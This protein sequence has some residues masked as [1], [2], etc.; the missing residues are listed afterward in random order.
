MA[1]ASSESTPPVPVQSVAFVDTTLSNSDTIEQALSNKQIV[2]LPSETNGV[3]E[4]T[5]VLSGYQNLESIHIF[6]Y[7]NSGTLQLGDAVLSQAF[8]SEYSDELQSWGEALISEGDVFL[9]GS[10]VAAG[11]VGAA[12]VDQISQLTGADVAA[13]DDITGQTSLGDDWDLE[14]ATGEVGA[15]VVVNE[16]EGTLTINDSSIGDDGGGANIGTGNGLKAEYYNKADFTSP[17][18]TRTDATVDFDWGRR[19]PDESI[20][21]NTFSARWTGQIESQF[22]ETYTFY[23]LADDGVRLW[24]NDQL[25]VDAFIDQ[26][27]TE[28]S[29]TID[30]VA[31]EKYDIRMEYYERGASAVAQLS[32]ESAS[33]V[34]QIIPRAQLYSP[35]ITPPTEPPTEPP[36]SPQ[37]AP[38]ARGSGD[39]L[40]GEYY[41]NIDFTDLAFSRID[42]RPSFNWRK[43][44]PAESMD[45]DTFSV[46]WTG[47]VESKF[48]ETYTF[49]TKADDN[50]RLWV[51][52]QLIIDAAADQ[53]GLDNSGTI[54]LI[55][56]QKY[57]IRMEY[58]EEEGRAMVRLFWSSASQSR[59]VIQRSQLY[60]STGTP[61]EPP[62]EPVSTFS[63]KDSVTILVSE[64]SETATFTAVRTGNAS[65][66]AVLEYTT[67]EVGDSHSA[68]ANVDYIQPSTSGTTNTGQIIF[69]IGETE[70]TVAVPIVDDAS[71]E[72]NETFAIGIQNSSTGTLGTPRTVLI[73]I[74]DDDI[75][76]V[77]SV[78]ESTLTV[79]EGMSAAS[80]TV[81]RSGDT[82][83]AASVEFSTESGS[84]I[85]NED[86][87]E[88]SGTLTFEASQTAQTILVPILDDQ[89]VESSETLTLTLSNPEGAVL[90]QTTSTITVLD[91]DLELGTLTRQTTISGLVQPI[92]LDWT[93]DGRYM[94]VAQ[95]NGVVK[96][97]DNG[98]LRGE[99]LINLSEQVNNTRDRGLI[100]I[101]VHPNF[102]ETPYVYLSYTY[103]PPETAGQSGIAGLDGKG[104]RP[105][106][107]VRVSVDLDTMIADPS[108]LVVLAGTNST[109]EYTSHPD[110][111]STGNIE[112]LP[113]GIVNGTTITAPSDQIDVGIQDNDPDR[114]GI[115]NQNIRDYL[116]T[117]SESHSIG[118]VNF[119]PDRMLYLS[120]GDGTSYN[121]ADPRSVRVQDIDNLSG[122]VL[123]LD[124]ITGK[125]L[126]DNPFYDGDPDSNRS[127]VFYSGVRNPFRFTFDPITGRPVIG[128]VGWNRWEEIN[129]GAP[130]SNFGWPY[131]EGPNQTGKYRFMP[132]AIAFYDNGNI[133]P[134]SHSDQA[135]VFPLLG[136]S[137]GAPD[138]ANAIIVGDFYN[139]NTLMFGDIN[140]GTL[141]AATLDDERQVTDVQVFDSNI[142]YV[143]DM[144]V[145][146]DGRLYGVN[147][148][149]GQILRWDPA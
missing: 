133:N 115:Q 69:E 50:V 27:P 38:P 68:T 53:D 36:T 143:V 16:Y 96:V 40:T 43:G 2:Q 74:L 13:S 45:A 48:S 127:K 24:V 84:A 130:G 85:A 46:R 54:D 26:S 33:Q 62:T 77:F 134:G 100:G 65:E 90:G 121:F 25:L 138:N 140:G 132:E 70:K 58:E 21:P 55:A 17:I 97:V 148:V 102:A 98:T 41:N 71:V 39:G 86:Y 42:K 10:N 23:T 128:D 105:S 37:T 114:P 136:R 112:I 49:Y 8:M 93:P 144:E 113:S 146:P 29:G 4:I 56:G 66:R 110:D 31:G 11:T 89:K 60:S 106:R 87:T 75:A 72:S 108:S 95:K 137:H 9:Y 116:A 35:I 147:L 122:K 118:A 34:K 92:A 111:N 123:R 51:D 94:F 30:L 107:L 18:L 76:S 73:T 104:N 129:T 20:R 47:Q 82:S 91:N 135:A 57:D 61:T 63:L 12:F 6:S 139:E 101:A 99:A 83:A 5:Q 124:P 109:W 52:N 59:T 67:N 79:S 3:E 149:S 78:T 44:T 14:I 145:G 141:Y 103:D 19:S 126:S 64:S 28:Y 119:G 81:Q 120:N 32:W 7:G 22:S 80:I 117:D 88:V 142:S 125:G 1:F 131:L 15:S